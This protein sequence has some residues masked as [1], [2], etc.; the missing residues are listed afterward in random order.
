METDIQDPQVREDVTKGEAFKFHEGLFA[1]GMDRIL[2]VS[3]SSRCNAN[4]AMGPL[5]VLLNRTALLCCFQTVRKASV[6]F[7]AD[8]HLEMA[9]YILLAQQSEA[10]LPYIV[11]KL[12][13]PPCEKYR[14]FDAFPGDAYTQGLK[15]MGW[16]PPPNSV[17]SMRLPDLIQ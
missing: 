4:A 6:D 8:F 1:S 15:A 16:L 11:E 9:K 14:K 5:T 17:S 7:Y 13:A 2:A 3:L 10:K 12:L